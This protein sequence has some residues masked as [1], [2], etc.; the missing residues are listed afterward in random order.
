MTDAEKKDSF[1]RIFPGRVEKLIK[2]LKVLCN[3]SKKSGYMWDQD[4]VHDV[5]VTI[6]TIFQESAKDFGV[7]FSIMV[8]GEE[9]QYVKPKRKR[10]KA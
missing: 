5:W 7:D 3:C 9:V 8:D 10:K 2:S 4:L 1:S 6:A